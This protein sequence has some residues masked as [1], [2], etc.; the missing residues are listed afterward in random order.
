MEGLTCE[1]LRKCL[2]YWIYAYLVL[3]L[4]GLGSLGSLGSLEGGFEA[5]EDVPG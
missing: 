4:E 2:L 1:T 3:D 5:G